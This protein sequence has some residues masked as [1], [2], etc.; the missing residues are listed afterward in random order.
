LRLDETRKRAN[1]EAPPRAHWAQWGK[2]KVE[3]WIDFPA[4]KYHRQGAGVQ[5]EKRWE[6]KC[7]QNYRSVKEKGEKPTNIIPP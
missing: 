2:T 6:N 3:Q 7:Q 1:E 5:G 4:R